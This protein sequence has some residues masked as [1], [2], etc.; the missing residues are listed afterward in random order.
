[1]D[2]LK[3]LPPAVI[4]FQPMEDTSSPIVLGG[5]GSQLVRTMGTHVSFISS[6]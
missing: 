2:P 6:G 3:V 1:M 4:R 5:W